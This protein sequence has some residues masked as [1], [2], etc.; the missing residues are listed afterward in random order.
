MKELVSVELVERVFRYLAIICPIAGLVV[1][2]CI[3]WALGKPRSA[4]VS[5]VILALVGVANYALWRLSGIITDRLGLDSVA[6]L[7]IQ[8]A[9]F[10]VVGFAVG[11]VVARLPRSIG[12]A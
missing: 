7:L 11:I 6:N 12:T 3:H 10:L 2:V 9:M 8:A 4:V 1:A 5:G